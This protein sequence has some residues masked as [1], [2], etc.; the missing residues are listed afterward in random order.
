MLEEKTSRKETKLLYGANLQLEVII[1]MVVH[2]YCRQ[3]EQM[4]G[5]YFRR[6]FRGYFRGA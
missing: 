5:F 2:V 6:Y 3:A 1:A 4:C